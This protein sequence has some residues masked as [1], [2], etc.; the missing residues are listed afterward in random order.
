MMDV[1]TYTSS[2]VW[3]TGFIHFGEEVDNC[4]ILYLCDSHSKLPSYLLDPSPFLVDRLVL[5]KHWV[6]VDKAF[7]GVCTA[8]SMFLEIHDR[9]PVPLL[10]MD[11]I[12]ED[13]TQEDVRRVLKASYESMDPPMY[14]STERWATIAALWRG[15]PVYQ[16]IAHCTATIDE[17][18]TAGQKKKQKPVYA[19]YGRITS[20][21]SIS[22]QRDRVSSHF[23]VE[24]EDL[25]SCSESE[26]QSA[27]NVMFTGVYNMRWHLFFRP[28]KIVLLTDLVK[29]LSR[30]C[31]MFLLQATHAHPPHHNLEPMK[32][33]TVLL[34]DPPAYSRDI[35]LNWI[36]ES[37]K[38]CSMDHALRCSGK[39]LDYE[40]K[41]I[42]LL[43]DEC[44]E[45]EGSSGTRIIVS[46]FHFPFEEELIHFRKGGSVRVCGAHVLRWPTPAGGKLVIG[47]CPRSHFA[48]VAYADPSSPCIVA[49][50]RS[51]RSRTNG[52]WSCFGDVHA[53]SMVLS[54]W[55]LELLEVVDKQFFFG[56]VEQARF[57]SSSLSF[58]RTRRRRAVAQVAKTLCLLPSEPRNSAAMSLS[59][60]FLKCHS[61]NAENCI[62]LSFPHRERIL[63]W[64]KA[65]TIRELQ[66][67]AESVSDHTTE[68]VSDDVGKRGEYR[69]MCIS[70][71]GLSWC[72]LLAGIRGSID[73]GD[74]EV[75]DRTGSIS[76]ILDWSEKGMD[77]VSGRGVYLICN[78]DIMVDVYNRLGDDQFSV[79]LCIRCSVAD[80]VF[81]EI[82]DDEPV[83]LYREVSAA[84]DEAH[85]LQ[86]A[87]FFVSHIDALPR[88][89]IRSSE[90]LPEYRLFHGIMCPVGESL[91]PDC[92]VR[93]L[94][95]A[96]ILV[97]SKSSHWYLQKEGCY[98][99][100]VLEVRKSGGPRVSSHHGIE[101]LAVEASINY[102]DKVVVA[103]NDK[104]LCFDSLHR[105][106]CLSNG[107]PMNRERL[108][109][110]YQVDAHPIV[111]V[112]LECNECARCKVHELCQQADVDDSG[113]IVA[114]V[115]NGSH[116]A[117]VSG[118]AKAQ[119]LVRRMPIK[120]T[121]SE[122][123]AMSVLRYFLE[124]SE[125][126]VSVSSLLQ[127]PLTSGPQ[128]SIRN[129][130]S[131]EEQPVSTTLDPNLHKPHLVSVR[132][133][134]TKKKYYWRSNG[135]HQPLAS[136]GLSSL[137]RV[138]HCSRS[139][140]QGSSGRWICILY[141]RDLQHLDSVEVRA[142]TSLFGLLG[143]L[144]QGTVVEISRLHGF[145]ARASYK[146]YLKW[147]H[148]T[149]AR[150]LLSESDGVLVPCDAEL[151]GSLRTTFLNGLYNATNIDQMLHR[152]VVGVM[153]MSYMLL[154]R[155]CSLCHQALQLDKRRGCVNCPKSQVESQSLR[156]CAW[157]W[158]QMAP[159]DAAITAR[160]Y[161]GT[162]VRCIIDD[163]SGQAELFLEDDVAW[164]LLECS[165]GQR[166]RF[167]DVVRNY[168]SQLSYFSGRSATASFATSKA[169][170][171]QEYYQN[172]LRA[173]VLDA[174]PSLRSIVVFA[175]QFFSAKQKENT[176]VLTFGK[177][178]HI[179]TSTM[180]LPK[181]EAKRVD[182]VHVRD[183]LKRRL[184][185]LQV[186]FGN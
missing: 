93:S 131:V 45:L 126:V 176:S 86:E 1:V 137:E 24:V 17:V 132:G 21:S 41:V 11:E 64:S 172:E 185:Q 142:D 38:T 73:N 107:T 103:D 26:T 76:M 2:H 65:L 44:I 158:Q 23:F 5:V 136:T 88:S 109:R 183:E 39:L 35:K 98:R 163:G 91:Q 105:F 56:E 19:V 104:L 84:R 59:A 46:L 118:T 20:V 173:F 174:I 36:D 74:L 145:T 10:P 70:A 22:R 130:N 141:V 147:S 186:D 47:L 79:V 43:W 62:A 164:E 69:S 155:K 114:G 156:D 58:P 139:V 53:Q 124:Q 68:A 95:T 71:K 67:F 13:W 115:N 16:D 92:F 128:Q 146:V 72:L 9:E 120:A 178:V 144:Q 129:G 181:L 138:W 160:T 177:D 157:R 49:G 83:G 27:V 40:G 80:V 111:P 150:R 60:L 50:T 8:G 25:Q 143:T 55:L 81:V 18:A 151:F 125:E 82:N 90:L 42:R 96:N 31:D 119:H 140:A 162:T 184:A 77:F 99:V 112:R 106:R 66:A 7:G 51:Y 133:M 48:V 94:C 122:V 179:T 117:V 29:V 123:M 154:K 61:A 78:F 4:N 180:A 127:Q 97:S 169:E 171:E 153:H 52:K 116:D 75:Y 100:R 30:E 37:L 182:R 89:S 14:S 134:I 165:D 101:D 102:W 167:E 87:L 168:V 85:E 6:L 121:A 63:T 135:Q 110:V 152:Y 32:G 28:G 113:F 33:T 161:V 108:F 148:S 12:Y 34:W 170:R 57:Q 15:D 175:R 159:S 3:V 54:M 166:R 149:A